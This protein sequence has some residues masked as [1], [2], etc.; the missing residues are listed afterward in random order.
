L[1]TGG[2]ASLSSHINYSLGLADYWDRQYNRAIEQLLK[3]VELEPLLIIAQQVLALTCARKG[4]YA[5]AFEQTEKVLVLFGSDFRG[6]AT[7]ALIHAI[8]GQPAEARRILQYLWFQ[9]LVFPGRIF[10]RGAISPFVYAGS[11]VLRKESDSR[12]FCRLRLSFWLRTPGFWLP[13]SIPVW[14]RLRRVRS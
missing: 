9:I 1:R 7:A 11:E 6:N 3:T 14:F 4:M 5:A 12:V 8:A 10:P 13:A 2:T